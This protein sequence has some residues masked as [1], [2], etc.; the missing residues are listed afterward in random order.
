MKR[1][2]WNE[3]AEKVNARMGAF[4]VREMPAEFITGV[5][6]EESECMKVH[7]ERGVSAL[8]RGCVYMPTDSTGIAVV[9][10]CYG[11]LKEDREKG[12]VVLLGDFQFPSW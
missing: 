11:R 5:M 2:I 1:V 9:E 3:V 12:Q 4:L 10:S 8:Y 7:G 6:Y